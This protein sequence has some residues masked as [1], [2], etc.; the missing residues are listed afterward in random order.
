[1]KGLKL[2]NG[3]TIFADVRSGKEFSVSA[4]VN[5]GHVNEPRLGMAALY[6]KMLAYR[7]PKVQAVY[8]GVITS[9]LTGCPSDKLEET[10]AS[11]A[12]LFVAPEVNESLLAE[13]KEDIIRHTK[14]LAP[15]PKRQMKLLYKHTAF[16]RRRL[17]WD[18]SVYINAVR[19]YTLRQVKN[20]AAKYYVG[21][22]LVLVVSGPVKEDEL[23][24][25]ANKYF[26]ALPMGEKAELPQEIYTG[27]YAE[28]P[29]M[30]HYQQVMLGWDVSYLRDAAEAN[31]MMS[32][33]SGRLERSFVGMP[34]DCEVKIAGYYGRRT[35]R[36][37][38]SSSD[39]NGLNPAIDVVCVNILRLMKTFASERRMETSR[40]RAMC[41]KLFQFSQPQD[42]AIE[43]AWQLLGRGKAYDIDARIN[44]TWSVQADDVRDVACKIFSQPLTMVIT[45]AQPHY[46]EK[47]VS[48]KIK[49]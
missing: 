20:F 17:V 28:L 6:E 48:A 30:G 29:A 33:L 34:V 23:L 14:D 46:T 42:R 13:A 25:L 10:L 5:V 3:M 19:S 43:R 47:E 9:Y 40:N 16:G 24:A 26:G 41:E 27:G 12:K 45:S 35:L 31:V 7:C 36:I 18:T 21:A 11:L 37:S 22:N 44:N 2:E 39:P 8:G 15:L 38:V 1:M 32:M 4:T 49:L